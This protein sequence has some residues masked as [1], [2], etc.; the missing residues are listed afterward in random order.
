MKTNS[1]SLKPL[2]V[3]LVEDNPA[4]ARLVQETLKEG[5]LLV[6]LTVARDGFEALQI[7]GNTKPA[8]LP[9]LVLLDLNLPRKSGFEVLEE[10]KANELLRSIPIVIMTTSDADKDVVRSYNL[11]ANA[12]ITKPVALEEF[13]DTIRKTEEFWLTIV[14]YPSR[15]AYG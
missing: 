4:D 13:I 12:F 7:L 3:L 9:D 1:A 10:I 14:R 6:E 11:H 2:R 5:R 8:E 15:N